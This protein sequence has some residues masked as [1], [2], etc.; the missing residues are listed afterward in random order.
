MNLLKNR[1]KDRSDPKSYRPISLLPSLSKAL[2]Y[3]ACLRLREQIELRM[4]DQQFG[5]TV[6]KS[7]M[8]AI[9]RMREWTES[10]AEKYVWVFLDISGAF[11][12]VWWPAIL[13]HMKMLG[14]MRR[15]YEMT[16]SHLGGRYASITVPNCRCKRMLSKGSPQGS[17]LRAELLKIL[18]DTLLSQDESEEELTICYVD[19]ALLMIAVRTRK[20]VLKRMEEKLERAMSLASSMKLTFSVTKTKVMCLKGRLIPPYSVEMAGRMLTEVTEMEYYGNAESFGERC[21]PYRKGRS[22]PPVTGE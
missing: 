10:R 8:D 11:D 4:I 1:D 19:N 15:M 16:R 14:A 2:E 5:F 20:E 21:R 3:L 6:R 13:H 12:N 7:T 9:L 18:M 22:V 17:Q